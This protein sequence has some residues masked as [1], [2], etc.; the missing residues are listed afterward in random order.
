MSGAAVH[1]L[2]SATTG[3]QWTTTRI[4]S[5]PLHSTHSVRQYS[6]SFFI[7]WRLGIITHTVASTA[8]VVRFAFV[9]PRCVC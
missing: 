7:D 5:A 4:H 8:S 1:W 3:H 9:P 6:S 2:H